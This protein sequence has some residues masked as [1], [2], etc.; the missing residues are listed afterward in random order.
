MI[1][2][3]ANGPQSLSARNRMA[4]VSAD[5]PG[6]KDTTDS[7]ELATKNSC[8]CSVCT[9]ASKA[10][11]AP[12]IARRAGDSDGHMTRYHV[13]V[14]LGSTTVVQSGFS[15]AAHFIFLAFM[16]PTLAIAIPVGLIWC[17]S[18]A[19]TSVVRP[20]KRTAEEEWSQRTQ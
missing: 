8:H 11:A 20:K 12:A 18:A 19:T 5:V 16:M 4:N 17:G 3:T 13:A 9:Q 14:H 6:M 15:M 1:E 2:E 7:R 10:R